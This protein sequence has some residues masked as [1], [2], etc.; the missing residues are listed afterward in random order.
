MYHS[1][2]FD[3]IYEYYIID[4][5][6]GGMGEVLILKRISKPRELDFIHQDTLAAKTFKEDDNTKNNSKLFERELFIW[7]NF[8]N[9]IFENKKIVKL[10]KTTFINHKLYALMPF[11]DQSVADIICEKGRVD[12]NESLLI[13]MDVVE[14][15]KNIFDQYKV[16]HQDLKPANILCKKENNQKVEYHVSDWGISNIQKNLCP[17]SPTNKRLPQSFVETM[18]NVGTL[19]YMSPERLIGASSNFLADIYSCGLIFYEL[20]FG[21]LPLKINSKKPLEYQ[22]LDCDYFEAALWALS[23]QIKNEKI[24]A[25]IENCIHPD[26]RKRYS[27]YRSLEKS[28][29]NINRKKFLF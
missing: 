18:S 10:L 12:L 17:E 22:I 27:D 6:T 8:D 2:V 23:K 11:Y 24:R 16:V 7:L 14:A 4:K 25:I 15:L 21:D 9:N 29:K 26:P 13:V 28:L 20:L 3:A 5:K 1:I 19:P